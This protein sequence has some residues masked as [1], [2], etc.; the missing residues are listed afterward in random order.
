MP[1][2][3]FSVTM[4]VR[5]NVDTIRTCLDS[6]LP[7]VKG[8]GEIVVVDARSND[9]TWE[10][11]REIS[12]AHPELRV[13]SEPA[14]RGEGRNRA[15]AEARYPYLLTHVDGD[16]RYA[17]GALAAAA[18]AIAAARVDLLLVEGVQDPNPACTRCYAWTRAGF[19]RVGGYPP[20]Q[21]EEDIGVL[22]RALR[23]GIAIGR[24]HLPRVGDDLKPRPD[25]TAYRRPAYE[26]GPALVRAA[27]MFRRVGYTYREYVR[28]LWLTRH[29]G[30]RF[31]LGSVL[32]AY[33]YLSPRGR[34]LDERR[35]P[36][37]GASHEGAR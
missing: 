14:N 27:R 1:D 8:D 31:A 16:N 25:T 7:Q 37:A 3:G 26:R 29:G 9:G 19:V 15:A 21:Y 12:A 18:R 33:G 6:L 35:P 5:N 36:S 2:P 20:T 32:G 22:L 10:A 30:V 28:F 11:L 17:P 24:L 4:T 23:A 34:A 13:F